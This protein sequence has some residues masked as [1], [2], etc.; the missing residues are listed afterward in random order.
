MEEELVY[1]FGLTPVVTSCVA[2]SYCEPVGIVVW[3]E[4]V[5]RHAIL[6]A[7][8]GGVGWHSVRTPP[9]RMLNLPLTWPPRP[10]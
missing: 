6:M 3:G 2:E 9:P 4:D 5:A 8:G 10:T 1:T 7:R